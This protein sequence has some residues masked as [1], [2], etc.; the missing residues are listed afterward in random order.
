MMNTALTWW[1][2][3]LRVALTVATGMLIGINRE[4]HGRAAGL[5]T[6]LLVS[7]AACFS[8]LQANALLNTVGKSPD[9]FIVLDLMR[10]PL[11]ILSGMGFIGAGAILHKGDLVQ[12]V[13]TAATLWFVTVI[14]LCFGGGQIGLGLLASILGIDVLWGLKKMERHKRQYHQSHLV[15][16]FE[17]SRIAESEVTGILEQ[18][19]QKPSCLGLIYTEQNRQIELSCNIR[20]RSEAESSGPPEPIK[21]L[22][23][24][25]GILKVAW[26]PQC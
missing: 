13:T 12:G 16:A 22:M 9:S 26:Q 24:R 17:A 15:I 4:E 1:D 19:P 20:I 18:L 14:G 21:S 2:V 11:G 3:V 5:R 8:M 7:L 25:P 23:Q 10:L 6:T